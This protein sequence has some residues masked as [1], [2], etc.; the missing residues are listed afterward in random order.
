MS[1]HEA[2]CEARYKNILESGAQTRS[3]VD[4]LHMTL[5]EQVRYMLWALI[6]M[7]MASTFGR[8]VVA[9]LVNKYLGLA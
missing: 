9:A 3:A 6:V 7:A 1:T 8:D 2:V 4:S 5:K